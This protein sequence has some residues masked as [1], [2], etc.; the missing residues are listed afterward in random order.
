MSLCWAVN[1][2]NEQVAYNSGDRF[3]MAYEIE[4]GTPVVAIDDLGGGGAVVDRVCAHDQLTV[5]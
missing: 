4:L 1:E 2:C 3:A 5:G